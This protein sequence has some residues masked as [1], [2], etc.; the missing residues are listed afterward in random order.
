MENKV[1][2]LWLEGPLQSWGDRSKFELRDTLNFPTWSALCGM[3]CAA[4]GK[5][6]EQKEF[7]E[8]LTKLPPRIFA[9]GLPSVASTKLEDFQTIGSHFNE[10]DPFEL[11]MIPKTAEGKKATGVP[12]NVIVYK[13]AMQDAFFAIELPLE[14][15]LAEEVYQALLKPYWQLYLG[16]KAYVPSDLIARGVFTSFTDADKQME[17]IYKQKNLK[18]LFKVVSP[19]DACDEDGIAIELFDVPISFGTH[20]K[21]QS[22]SAL[23]VEQE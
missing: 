16:R 5:G 9:F 10:D 19:S 17:L 13:N 18:K 7:L 22:R 2:L 21:Y 1:L 6:G 8:E 12:G 15:N 23:I 20:K 11:L 14:S 3:M 4:L